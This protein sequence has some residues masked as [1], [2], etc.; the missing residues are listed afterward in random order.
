MLALFFFFFKQET[1][2]EVRISDWSSDV[3]S[4][5]LRAAGCQARR[6]GYDALRPVAASQPLPAALR[7]R[8]RAAA[9]A[10]QG[11]PVAES[12]DATDSKSVARKGVP[13][14]VRR[15]EERRVGKEGVSTGRFGWAPSQ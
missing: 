2:Y 3:C 12:V 13:V 7:H 14:R 11:A 9:G 5:D 8:Q 15:S 6:R 10:S 1:A 4:S